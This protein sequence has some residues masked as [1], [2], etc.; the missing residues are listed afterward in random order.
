MPGPLL[1]SYPGSAVETPNKVIDDGEFQLSLAHF[2]SRPNAVD[3][4][5]P[6]P[7]P[8]H[9]QYIN[10]LFNGILQGVGR[11]VDVPHVPKHT[12]PPPSTLH[13]VGRPAAISRIIKH[14]RGHVDW[15]S[16]VKRVWRRSPLWLLIRIAIQM[17]VNPSLGCASYKRFTLFLT[18][19]LARD[20][21]N[22]TLSSDHLHLISSKILRRLA[23]LGS[24]TPDWLSETALE[25]CGCLREILDTRWEQLNARPSPFRNPSEDELA[26]DTQLS[27]LDSREYIR[28][29]LASLGHESA[30]TSFHPRHRLRSTI[31]DFLSSNGSFFEEAY[32]ANP[33]VTLYDV[34]Q[35]V[36][37]GIDD[38]FACVTNVDEACAQ[39]EILMDNT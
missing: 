19:T 22:T 33:D 6:L 3:S 8:A 38:W 5:L 14:V 39:L 9:P 31:E 20:A 35:L 36:E 18:C 21:N 26:R 2:L 32:D 16:T 37:E 17:S 29:A 4:D 1:C 12:T 24:S 11:V 15:P 25:T 34:E 10:A 30:G 13:G 28:N 27:L 23:K 7:P